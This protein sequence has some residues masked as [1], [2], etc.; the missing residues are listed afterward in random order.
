MAV[1]VEVVAVGFC[2]VAVRDLKGQSIGECQ[3]GRHNENPGVKQ[4][5]HTQR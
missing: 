5:A 2:F 1:D 3:F 4:R